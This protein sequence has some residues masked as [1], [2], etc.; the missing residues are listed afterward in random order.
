MSN[1]AS[2][3]AG[4]GVR[5]PH[6]PSGA[7]EII[8]RLKRGPS[9]RNPSAATAAALSNQVPCVR[10]LGLKFRRR[11]HGAAFHVL[12]VP[13]GVDASAVV[14]RLRR[15][16]NVAY[17]E[18]NG[19]FR[20]AS[21]PNDP[22]LRYQWN[23]S[24]AEF[25]LHMPAVWNSA[26]GKGVIV[27]VLD[28]GIAYEDRGPYR[29]L[30]DFAG[31]AFTTGYDFVNEDP[32][33]NDDHR[34]GTHVAGVIAQATDNGLG[35]AGIAPGVTL[36]PVK[37]LDNQALGRDD[38]LASGIR[39]AVDHGARILN[40]SLG[41]STESQTIQEAIDYAV[42]RGAL[43]FAATGNQGTDRVD[44]PAR[45]AGV[46]AVGATRYD[47]Q[48]CFYSNYGPEQAF[49]A[50]GGDTRVDQNGDGYPDGIL[51]Q[52]LHEK[53]VALFQYRYEM[54][55]SFAVAHAS[56]MA[57][58]LWSL[59]PE[60][61]ARQIRWCLNA[62]ARDLGPPG[63]DPQY[64]YGLLD[65]AAAVAL[66]GGPP[67]GE[68]EPE[69]IGRPLAIGPPGDSAGGGRPTPSPAETVPPLATPPGAGAEAGRPA[70]ASGVVAPRDV[71]LTLTSAPHEVPVGEAFDLVVAVTNRSYQAEKVAVS[72]T[73]RST[74]A[75]LGPTRIELAA[76]ARAEVPF[77]TVAVGPVGQHLWLARATLTGAEDSRP[78]DNEQTAIVGVKPPRLNLTLAPSKPQFRRSE[79]IQ[80]LLQAT[81]AGDAVAGLQV[82]ISLQN[83]EGQTVVRGT[84][85]TS[86][87][88]QATVSL[89]GPLL[90]LVE[91]LYR[92][93]AVTD[94]GPHPPATTFTTFQVVR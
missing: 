83:P 51:Q 22:F 30:P 82:R 58:L 3:A 16:P 26:T 68:A 70:P 29:R 24:D 5:A 19:W 32:Y 69:P 50:P 93:E 53:S 2:A 18:P 15:D 7:T 65:A 61:S 33:A 60:W 6:A 39:F 37:V 20:A 40:M 48:R 74:G 8:V 73:N 62:S 85:L 41:S 21:L 84:V 43:L 67:P 9:S 59:R 31:T 89:S 90:R 17:A 28:T 76:G 10:Q 72:L 34:H 81:A 4:W 42:A 94:S 13:P 47:G 75:T 11:G 77:Q 92:A 1:G 71:A 35:A 87:K 80:L 49:V 63:P 54:G 79:R 23:L 27:A 38:W 36:M 55:T 12:S 78:E 44:F 66:A 46:C 52:S 57:A 25:G 91:G 86:T 64:G 45:A 14:Q 56:G 88:G